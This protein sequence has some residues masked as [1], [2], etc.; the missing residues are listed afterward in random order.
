MFRESCPPPCRPEG[1]LQA[2]AAGHSIVR[3]SGRSRR[4]CRQ[5]LSWLPNLDSCQSLPLSTANRLRKATNRDHC[6]VSGAS[7]G[8]SVEVSRVLSHESAAKY[9][10]HPS[11]TLAT[12]VGDHAAATVES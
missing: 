5:L 4:G 10:L 8:I 11:F 3:S 2:T 12:E 7:H 6:A 9:L 1:R